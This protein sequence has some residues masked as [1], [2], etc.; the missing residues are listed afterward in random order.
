[1]LPSPI[2]DLPCYALGF[3]A[4]FLVGAR[5]AQ[6]CAVRHG[7]ARWSRPGRWINSGFEWIEAKEGK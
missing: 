4:G 5:Y 2:I 7:V 6:V 3:I 1:M